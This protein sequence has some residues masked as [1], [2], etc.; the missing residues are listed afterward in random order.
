[1]LSETPLEVPE[2]ASEP[3]ASTSEEQRVSRVAEGD[4]DHLLLNTRPQPMIQ[5]PAEIRQVAPASSLSTGTQKSGGVLIWV[6]LAVVL[7]IVAVV[8]LSFVM[9]GSGSAAS[10]L[11]EPRELI[12]AWL[13]KA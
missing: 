2:P 13:R 7:A 10:S 5:E 9:G 1:M 12:E 6:I 4:P 11:L 8:V 3:P